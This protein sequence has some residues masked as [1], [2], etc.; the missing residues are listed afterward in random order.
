MLV[1]VRRNQILLS[2]L[3]CVLFS[4]YILFAATRGQLK[5]D[6]IGPLLIG[7]IR[8]FQIGVQET[9]VWVRD[10]REDFATWRGLAAQNE[11]LRDQLQELEAERNRLLEAQATNNRLRELLEL[12]SQL[13]SQSIAATVIAS[14]A[15]TWFRSLI[16]N[17]G[18]SD[19]V[20]KG[21][22]VVSP[23]GVVGQVVAV[24]SGSAKVLLV[25]DPSSGV[26]VI[27]QRTRS[28]GIVSGSL[29][30]GPVMKY[31]QRSE[32][33]QEGDRL[34]TSGLGGV[35]PKGLFVGTVD[36]VRKRSFGMFQYVGV[37]LAADLSRM[38]EVLVVSST[39][40]QSKN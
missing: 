4:L 1:F 16:L 32:D 26:D 15:S 6:P 30:D 12:R 10:I 20:R 24:T 34:V 21:M 28:R 11:E 36:E 22:A 2:S 33:I 8:P 7:L 17:K 31:V 13:S 14:S 5:S 35:F 3:F 19:G 23:T 9:I 18:S 37:S 29:D 27:V 25:T 38:E 39:A 40:A